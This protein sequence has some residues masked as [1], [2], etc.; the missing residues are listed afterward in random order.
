MRF[1]IQGGYR[2]FY[3]RNTVPL[4]P[5]VVNDI[6]KRGG[7]ILGTSRGGYDTSK[8]VDSIQDRGIN[9]VLWHHPN[10][11]C[12]AGNC[13]SY[14]NDEWMHHSGLYNWRRWNSERGFGDFWGNFPVCSQKIFCFLQIIF[15][16]FVDQSQHWMF[17]SRKLEDVA[18]KLLWLEFQRPLT[19]TFRYYYFQ[20]D[21]TL[22][23]FKVS[24]KL[25]SFSLCNFLI[26]VIDKS[27]GF[28]TAVEEAQRAIN[29]AHVEAE[30]TENGIGVVKLM[31]R[32]SG[33]SWADCSLKTIFT[34]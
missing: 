18:S 25:E 32:Y 26:Q 8:I 21:P 5:K 2:G 6:H 34:W 22:F 13:G 3:A 19:M 24:P 30:S 17:P 23:W 31:G 29:A 33:K 28:D 27:F 1:W 9:Q 4:S 15:W 14:R 7:T 11:K 10:F 20:I 12:L 16:E